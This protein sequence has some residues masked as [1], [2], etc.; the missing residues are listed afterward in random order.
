MCSQQSLANKD[1]IQ[2]TLIR[3]VGRSRRA[4]TKTYAGIFSSTVLVVSITAGP[5]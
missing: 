3:T 5:Y 1:K 2:K 4:E